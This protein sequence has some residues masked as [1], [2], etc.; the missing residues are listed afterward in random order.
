MTDLLLAYVLSHPSVLRGTGRLMCTAAAALALLG[1]RLDRLAGHFM[2]RGASTPN[3]DTLL[4]SW[5][6][7]AVPE[8]IL[9]WLAVGMLFAIGFCLAQ[10]ARAIERLTQSR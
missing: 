10:G 5:L 8:T 1:L 6:A 4:P 7:W 2:P 3:L 9:G